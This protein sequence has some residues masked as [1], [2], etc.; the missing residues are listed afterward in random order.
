MSGM[1]EMKLEPTVESAKSTLKNPTDSE[2]DA[3]LNAPEL[4]ES[5]EFP[6]KDIELLLAEFDA[7]L[8]ETQVEADQKLESV[9]NAERPL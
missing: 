6:M 5:Y 8:P 4:Y 2:I 9:E 7:I 1:D 3:A